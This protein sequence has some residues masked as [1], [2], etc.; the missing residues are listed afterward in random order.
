MVREV[1]LFMAVFM[2]LFKSLFMA[3][4]YTWCVSPPTHIFNVKGP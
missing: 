4:G 1:P 3:L 2:A